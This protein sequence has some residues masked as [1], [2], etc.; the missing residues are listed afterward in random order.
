[1][2]RLT[3]HHQKENAPAIINIFGAPIGN[4]LAEP[5]QDVDVESD[6]DGEAGEDSPASDDEWV[7]VEIR[8]ESV[9]ESTT[10]R[11]GRAIPMKK[12]TVYSSFM[13]GPARQ[14]SEVP[15]TTS[16]RLEFFTCMFLFP[17]AIVQTIVL[18]TNAYAQ[19]TGKENG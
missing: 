19:L 9:A 16:T 1:M 8:Q 13:G 2:M 15:S 4:A 5:F 6:L 10:L 11:L 3:Q 17:I 12:N 14:C 7:D 18:N